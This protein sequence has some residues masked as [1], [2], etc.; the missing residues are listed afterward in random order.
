MAD[1]NGARGTSDLA[2]LVQG[3]LESYRSD[4]R[5][6][7]IGKKFLPSRDEIVEIIDLFL[8][9]FFPGYFGRQGL[10]EENIGYHVGQLLSTLRDKLA[11]Q[12]EQCL[13]HAAECGLVFEPCADE[14]KRMAREILA[15]VPKLRALIITDVQAAFDGDPA[16]TN[17]HEVILAY[18]GL[19][20]VAIYRVAHELRTIG[21]PLLPRIMTEWA[22]AR[23]GADIHPGATIGRSFFIDHATGVVIGE[24]SRI[25]EH[26]KLYQGVTLGALSHPRDADGRVIRNTKRHPTVENDVTIYANATVLGGETTV[27]RGSVVG[28]SVFMTR[29]VPPES[30]V[31]VKPPEL[32]VRTND[33]AAAGPREIDFE[34]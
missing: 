10:T 33:P 5:A 32:S 34:I 1:S 25:G 7:H 20:A 29:T 18:P 28:G 24:T 14:A 6:H 26:V 8:Q 9:L 12:I 23:T 3:L 4:S 22:H 21:V 15:R 2:E 16:A 30:R 19:L 17:L 27:G 31:A 11:R 13:C